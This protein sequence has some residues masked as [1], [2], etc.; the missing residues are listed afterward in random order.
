M[1]YHET[2]HSLNHQTFVV[3][4]VVVVDQGCKSKVA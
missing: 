4:V 1:D 3:V 2:N